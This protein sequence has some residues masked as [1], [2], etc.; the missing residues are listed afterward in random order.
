MSASNS[1]DTLPPRT[2][3]GMALDRAMSQRQYPDR[4]VRWLE[5]PAARAVAASGEGVLIAAGGEPAL[6][7]V[8]PVAVTPGKAILLGLDR[9]G[10]PLF[11]SDLD[12][13]APGEAS[14]VSAAGR[15]VSLREAG[16]VLSRSEGGLA[17]Y[18][19]ALLGWHRRNRFCANC[20][21]L[22]VIAQAGSSRRCPR[23][24]TVHFPRMD[25]VV[26][27]T[28]EH[29]GRL[30]LGRREGWPPGRYSLLAG[31]VAPGETTEE[32]V[33]REVHEESGIIARDP[34]FVTSQPWPFPASL[35]FGFDA[36]S[37]GGRPTAGDGELAEVRWFG[38]E[39]VRAA[40]NDRDDGLRLPPRVSIARFLIERWVALHA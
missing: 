11:A 20:G 12:A 40:T 32:A 33:V 35:M 16:A 24:A 30:L 23:C 25:P 4:V 28:V 17:A 34:T 29:E 19:V 3:S 13:L 39:A 14:A 26:I 7:R 5:D 27:M 15:I 9:N 37:D 10:A 8:A 18:L 2:F 36:Q 21:S 1:D 38:H 22:T 31:F 6:R